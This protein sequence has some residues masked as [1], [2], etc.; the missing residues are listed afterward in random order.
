MYGTPKIHKPDV[1][2]RPIVSGIGSITYAAAKYL[3]EIMSP[4]VGKTIHHVKNSGE[5]VKKIADITLAEDEQ[6]VSFDVSALFT[7]IPT[8]DALS[9]IEQKLR[10][11]DD[12]KKRTKLTIQQ[13]INLL[14]LC[15]NTT[16][17]TFREQI[18]KQSF[19]A[20]MGSPVSPIVAN[21][22]MEYFELKAIESSPHKPRL[23]YRYVDDTFVIINKQH[24]NDFH[25]HINQV[26]ENIKFTIEPQQEGK[27]PFLD[28]YIIVD[29]QQKL[30]TKVFRKPTHTDQYLNGDSNHHLQHKRSVVRSLMYRADHLIT[31]KEDQEKEKKY[32]KEVLKANNYKNWAFKISKKT[33]PPRNQTTRSYHRN[34][35][36]MLPYVRG[37]S[38]QLQKI[39]NKHGVQVCHKPYNTLRQHLV[40]PKDPTPDLERC[41]IIYECEC[42]TCKHSYIGETGR[43]LEIRL[44][45]HMK[46]KG[47]TTAIGDHIIE[48]KHKIDIKNF[49]ILRSET[50]KFHRKVKEAIIIKREKPEMNRDDGHELPPI[51][52]DLLCSSRD[53]EASA[54][55]VTNGGR[56]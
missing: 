25:S 43:A 34:T 50:L 2:L 10:A 5:F 53:R 49:K 37:L 15:L 44:K 35:R 1:P 42:P 48:A 17:F 8:K 18:Y 13:I 16:Y 54:D 55:H 4:L 28:I 23:W 46:T 36:I 41:G 14:E 19:G 7:S 51:Y 22:Y 33:N 52:D 38:E 31:D 47:S 45:E 29:E 40:K 56:E 39:Y 21:L 30:K 9:V 27:I 12:L 6:M 32:I 11:D 24:I 20:A 3:A 26:D